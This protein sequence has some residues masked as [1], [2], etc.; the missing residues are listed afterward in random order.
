MEREGIHEKEEDIKEIKKEETKE[1]REAE[2]ARGD[3]AINPGEGVNPRIYFLQ[4][5]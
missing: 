3:V 1:R 4:N 5:V 2:D